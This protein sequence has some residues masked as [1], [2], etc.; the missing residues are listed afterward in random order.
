[1]HNVKQPG[2][3]ALAGWDERSLALIRRTVAQDCSDD[4]FTV[5]IHTARALGLDP[6]RRQV[7][8]LVFNGETGRRRLAVIAGIDGLR[9]IAERTESYRPDEDEPSFRIDR[10]IKGTSNPAGLVKATVRVW[11]HVHGGWHRVTA[12]A[13]WDEYAPLRDEWAFDPETDQRQP[14][15]RKI[16]PTESPWS[17]MPRLMLAK[18]AEALALRKAWPDVFGNVYGAEEVERTRAG[19]LDSA[20]QGSRAAAQSEQGASLFVDWR[21]GRGLE[22]VP[23]TEMGER[24]SSFIEEHRAD[25]DLVA[26]W[27]AVNRQ[28]MRQFWGHAPAT[29]LEVKRLLEEVEAETQARDS[30]MHPSEAHD[31]SQSS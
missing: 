11:K 3:V 5:F 12:G 17:R 29:A 21:T 1:M 2:P 16:L 18:A 28:A 24:C 25:P 20:G 7:H 30:S 4:E 15:G 26:S 9:A 14:T 8:A 10:K 27:H 13:Y 23:V 6:L 31:L 22:S 19:S